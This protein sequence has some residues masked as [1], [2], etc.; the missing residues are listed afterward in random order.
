MESSRG[1]N[2]IKPGSVKAELGTFCMKSMGNDYNLADT[3]LLGQT[4]REVSIFVGSFTLVFKPN[5]LQADFSE[6]ERH[7]GGFGILCFT[8]KSPTYHN[9]Q[10]QLFGQK[11]SVLQPLETSGCG[12]C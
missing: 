12:H 10:V 6:V 7:G 1:Y 8:A 5:V 3:F 4:S 11:C 2:G 9:G